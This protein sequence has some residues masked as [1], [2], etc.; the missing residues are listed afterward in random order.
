VVSVTVNLSIKNVPEELAQRL[1]DR[2]RRHRRSLQ[3]ELLVILEEAAF[4]TPSRLSLKDAY[5]RVK[6]LG[7]R[8]GA[9]A[10]QMIRE[11]RDAR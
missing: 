6:R 3:K 8:T 4:S 7:L 10:T 11:D 2:A 5:L 9:E 1:R